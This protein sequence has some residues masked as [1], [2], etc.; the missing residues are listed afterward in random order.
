MTNDSVAL[1]HMIETEFQF[2]VERGFRLVIEDPNNV[3][4]ERDDGV[5]VRV[6][7]D[8][9]DKYLGYRIGL[10]SRPLDALTATE[11]ARLSGIAAP[12]GEYPERADQLHTSVARI[13]QDLRTHGER[14][15]SGDE[16]IYDEAMDLRRD[17][18]QQFTRE[19]QARRPEPGT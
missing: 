7:R 13:A 16:T 15:L 4:F 6:F 9:R 11:L 14:P 2:L 5:F 18:T 8:S 10:A 12:R 3:L 1:V 17:Y 19:P